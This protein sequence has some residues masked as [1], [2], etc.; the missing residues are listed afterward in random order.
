M[1]RSVKVWRDRVKN[2]PDVVPENDGR[3]P[4]PRIAACRS[5]GTAV[6]VINVYERVA[7]LRRKGTIQR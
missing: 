3:D 1:R 7:A 4:D 5:E 6:F 2:R